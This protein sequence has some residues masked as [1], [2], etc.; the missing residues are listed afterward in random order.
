MLRINEQRISAR[1]FSVTIVSFY[2]FDFAD[3]G[4]YF[5]ACMCN[6]SLG[7]DLSLEIEYLLATESLGRTVLIAVKYNLKKGSFWSRHWG[8]PHLPQPTFF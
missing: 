7:G 1:E 4:M 8:P 6:K 5:Y 3:R 2:W